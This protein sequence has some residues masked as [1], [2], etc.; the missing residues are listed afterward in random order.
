[1]GIAIYAARSCPSSITA[2]SAAVLLGKLITVTPCQGVGPTISETFI[3]YAPAAIEAKE[4]IAAEHII[5]KVG[6]SNSLVGKK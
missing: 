6:W 3:R 1:M 5:G 2:S 4:Q